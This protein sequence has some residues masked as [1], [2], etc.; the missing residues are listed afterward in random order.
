MKLEN[1]LE[2]YSETRKLYDRVFIKKEKFNFTP[3]LYSELQKGGYAEQVLYDRNY[4]NNFNEDEAIDIL[5]K[6]DKFTP[7][8][9]ILEKNSDWS[10]K[11]KEKAIKY[12][13]NRK[14]DFSV[15]YSKIPFTIREQIKNF[16]MKNQSQ[17]FPNKPLKLK[18][19]KVNVEE[20]KMD[21][22]DYLDDKEEQK[23]EEE[24]NENAFAAIG[25][26]LGYTLT[27]GILAFGGTLLVLGGKKYYGKMKE[28]WLRII[29][30][31]KK[32]EEEKS[33]EQAMK[34]IETSA[35]V[36]AEKA[37]IEAKKRTYEEQLHEVYLA[38]EERNFDAA[39]TAFY[40]VDRKIQDNPDV[41]KAIIFEVTKVLKEPPL[42]IKSPGN[43]SYQAIKKI[44]NIRVARSAAKATEMA[45]A[46]AAGAE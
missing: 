22:R 16:Q 33:V 28:L 19:S 36:K 41:H 38:I 43:N 6:N 18:E 3:E 39:K 24:L 40:Q 46:N 13:A 9:W 1:W 31:R 20:H 29:G 34:E 12:L 27:A 10:E 26:I 11:S 23:I 5:I 25:S 14:G 37:K 21:L 44:I 17:K 2:E 15:Y 42:Y 4:W 45:L 8:I 35:Q 30:K 32:P 7:L